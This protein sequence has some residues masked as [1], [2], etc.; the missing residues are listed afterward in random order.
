MKN[1]KSM[2][3]QDEDVKF[4]E[5][6]IEDKNLSTFTAGVEYIIREYKDYIYLNNLYDS[7]AQTINDEFDRRHK[8]DLLRIRLGS[9]TADRNVQ[10]LI[11]M[12]NTLLVHENVVNYF[13]TNIV[14]SPAY[15]KGQETVKKRIEHFKEMKDNKN[16][17]NK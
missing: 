4:I 2:Y 11:E 12:L 7:L 6:L 8:N 13:D 10:V 16:K 1:R 15:E 17:G 9:S 14:T 3:L 5:Q